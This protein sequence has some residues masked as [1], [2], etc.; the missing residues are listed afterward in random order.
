MRA[1]Q[2][3]MLGIHACIRYVGDIG[4]IYDVLQLLQIR[5]TQLNLYCI[6]KSTM[7]STKIGL[8]IRRPSFNYC[9]CKCM[10]VDFL[11]EYIGPPNCVYYGV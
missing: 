10:F 2:M 8:K 1:C 3:T 5:F 4:F 7:K 6:S 11:T 9:C